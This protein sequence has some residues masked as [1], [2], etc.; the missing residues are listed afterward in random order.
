MFSSKFVQCLVAHVSSAVTNAAMLP[1][2]ASSH[3][4]LSLCLDYF[5][6]VRLFSCIIS[7]CVLHYCDMMRWAWLDWGLSGWLTTLLQ[8]FDTVG[9][10]VRPAKTSSPKWPK[11]CSMLWNPAESLMNNW[12]SRYMLCMIQWTSHPHHVWLTVVNIPRP[13]IHETV[14]EVKFRNLKS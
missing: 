2:L 10:V 12:E 5:V 4:V 13:E 11:P 3:W 14:D 9:W 1:D 8:C 7:A 6:C